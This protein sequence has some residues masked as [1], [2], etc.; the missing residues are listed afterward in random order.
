M[1]CESPLALRVR[2]HG[3]A[4]AAAGTPS[5]GDRARRSPRVGAGRPGLP[6]K[7]ATGYY[8]IVLGRRS[9]SKSVFHFPIRKIKYHY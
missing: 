5:F 9:L 4:A 1:T 8:R 3:A 2:D 7:T 6:S